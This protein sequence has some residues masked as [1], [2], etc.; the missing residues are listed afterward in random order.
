MLSGF[1]MRV[2]EA[3]EYFAELTFGE[4]VWEEFHCVGSQAGGVLVESGTC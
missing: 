3:E 2:W 1:E 4:E